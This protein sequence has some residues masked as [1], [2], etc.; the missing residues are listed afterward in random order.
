MLAC[1]ASE[2]CFR[3]LLAACFCVAAAVGAADPPPPGGDD[4]KYD[5]VYRKKGKPFYGL[6]IEDKPAHVKLLSILRK[7]GAPTV[8]MEELVLRPEIDR[9]ETLEDADRDLLKQRVESLRRDRELLVAQLKLLDPTSRGKTTVDRVNLQPADWPADPKAKAV[10]YQSTHFKL[11]SNAREDVVQ[12]AA[13][14]LEQVYAAYARAL[15]SRAATLQPTTILLT[16]SVEDYQ[17]L[18]RDRGNNLVNPAYYDDAKNQIVCGSDLERLSK[19]LEDLHKHHAELFD[20]L[21][22]RENELKQVYK[23]TIP[24][25]LKGPLDDARVRIKVAEER[26]NEAFRQAQ[27]RLFQRLYHEAFHAYLTTAVYPR[28]DGEVPRWLNEGLAQIFETA[29]FEAGELRVGHADRVRLRAVQQALDKKDLLSLTDL[30]RSGPKQFQVEQ[31][32]DKQVSDRHYLASWALAFY[33]TFDRKVLGTKALDDYIRA[34]QR[35]TDPLDAFQDLVGVPLPQFEKDFQQY[36][37]RLQPD[38]S[39]LK[40]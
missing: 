22:K 20:E 30:L 18:A 6:I 36:L 21:N 3:L 38:G 34:L 33:L 1:V 8:V 12:L 19:Q 39:V 17:A 10:Q 29:I 37:R 4:W 24:N 26:N 15:P 32:A 9:V 28:A 7:P 14:Q 31:A 16:R 2:K 5:I 23:G 27:R 25:E 11:V 40:P 35:G 13:I